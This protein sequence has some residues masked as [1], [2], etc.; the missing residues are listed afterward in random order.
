MKFQG[1][2]AVDRVVVEGLCSC[3]LPVSTAEDVVD[4]WQLLVYV[5]K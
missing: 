4:D 2:F 1:L 5:Q 3:S